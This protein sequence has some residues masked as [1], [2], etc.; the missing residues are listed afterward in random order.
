MM[1]TVLSLMHAPSTGSSTRYNLH[2]TPSNVHWQSEP[3]DILGP[4]HAKYVTQRVEKD[5]N[6]G[7]QPWQHVVSGTTSAGRSAIY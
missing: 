7:C 1:F 3:K 6:Q 2:H 4:V 5:H